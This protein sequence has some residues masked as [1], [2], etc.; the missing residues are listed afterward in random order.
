ME[1]QRIAKNAQRTVTETPMGP[2]YGPL[3]PVDPNTDPAAV[4]VTGLD[5]L[6]LQAKRL[7][8]RL[9]MIE[10]MRGSDNYEAALALKR[11]AMEAKDLNQSFADCTDGGWI[12][13]I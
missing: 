2:I 13:H 9:D 6:R 1:M 3:V 7:N 12:Y 5:E 8:E 4:L 11:L 10:G